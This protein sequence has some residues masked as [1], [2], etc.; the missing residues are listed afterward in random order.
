MDLHE[1]AIR[2]LRASRGFGTLEEHVLADLARTLAY[3]H[4]AGGDPVYR[5][6]APSDSMLFVVSGGLR[7]SR[8]DNSG[9]LNLY[10]EVR[11]G[12]SVG[13][14]GLILQQPHTADVT[15]VRDSTLAILS[16][17][18]YEALLAQHPLAMNRVFVQVIYDFMRHSTPLVD[19]Q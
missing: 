12:Q 16:R 13:E 19:K 9:E 6:G 1:K 18:S 10:N 17:A 14:V 8:R 2:V 3:E 5:E 15:A 11:P 7:V 4:V